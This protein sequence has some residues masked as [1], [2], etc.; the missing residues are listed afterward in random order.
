MSPTA[1]PSP[2]TPPATDRC[3]LAFEVHDR[4]QLEL[5]FSFPLDGAERAPREFLVDAYFFVPRNVGLG[6]RPTTPRSSSTP[7]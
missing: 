2:A 6:P 4:H 3:R 5:R 7:T 1:A